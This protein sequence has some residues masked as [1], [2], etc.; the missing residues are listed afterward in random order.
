MGRSSTRSGCHTATDIVGNLSV[1]HQQMVEI[2]K[3]YRRDSV[4]AFDEPRRTDRQ[5]DNYPCHQAAP[6]Q[7]RIILYAPT[8]SR[9]I[10]ITDEIV[11]LKDGRLV[12]T[13]NTPETTERELVR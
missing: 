7:G 11:V 2:M 4:I 9:N 8:G 3:A 1:A 5:R 6:E 13:F 10:Q 12:R